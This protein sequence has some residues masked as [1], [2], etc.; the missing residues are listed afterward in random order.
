M[1]IVKNYH[2]RQGD[3]GKDYVTLELEGDIELVQSQNTGRFYATA[4]HCCIYSTFDEETAF[5]MIGQQMEGKIVRVPCEPY[6]YTIPESGLEVE[7]AHSW[8]Y[9]PDEPPVRK[10]QSKRE[11]IG[12][13]VTPKA[14]N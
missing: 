5:R 4:R 1:V 11:P 10:F 14:G 13:I 6:T 12:I 2:L 3:N 9:I 7:L 8:D